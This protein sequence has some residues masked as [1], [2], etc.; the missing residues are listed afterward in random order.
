[1]RYKPLEKS[2]EYVHNITKQI[3]SDCEQFI[4]QAIY[5]GTVL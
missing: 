4:E 2:K 3:V 5:C 1:M